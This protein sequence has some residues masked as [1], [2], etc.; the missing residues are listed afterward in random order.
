MF[1]VTE[2]AKRPAGRAGVCTYCK[3]PINGFHKDDC[4]LISKKV[5]V[6][7]TVEYEIEVPA[8]WDAEMVEY[9]RNE[10]SWCADNAIDEL[11]AVAERNGC[12]CDICRFEYVG[13]ES[14]P[15]LSE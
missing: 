14:D 6:R 1:K 4:V 10:G 2:K 9:H 8:S 12:L 15:F 13:N 5:K 11:E 7:M 3:E